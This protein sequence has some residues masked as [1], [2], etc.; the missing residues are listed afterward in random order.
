MHDAF[1][2]KYEDCKNPDLLEGNF[3][4]DVEA[5][6]VPL[7]LVL[8]R[9][10]LLLPLLLLLVECVCSGKTRLY[11]NDRSCCSD[12][13]YITAQKYCAKKNVVY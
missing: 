8:L 13:S 2:Y 1:I 12:N 11:M 7:L 10:P 6:W 5:D 3:A 4:E 9:P